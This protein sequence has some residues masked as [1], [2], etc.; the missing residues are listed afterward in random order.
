M[1]I[2]YWFPLYLST[3]DGMLLMLED[4]RTELSYKEILSSTNNLL[5][6]QFGIQK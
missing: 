2:F 3:L 1:H 4:L 6:N 5:N